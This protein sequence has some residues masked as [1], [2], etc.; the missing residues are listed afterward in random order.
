ME[1]AAA[2][3]GCT[4]ELG[5]ARH[6]T[7]AAGTYDAVLLLGPLYHLTER[8][9]RITALREALRVARGPGRGCGDQPVQPHVGVHGPRP[10]PPGT[11]AL[12]GSRSAV[13]RP[14]RRQ[15]WLHCRPL[16]HWRRDPC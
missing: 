3:A 11:P 4:T 15:S 6:L 14:V 10:T 12:R 13:R 2:Y 8:D 5:D 16:P 7:A 9:D 1:Q